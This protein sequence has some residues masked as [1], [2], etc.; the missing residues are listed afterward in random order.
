MICNV[1]EGNEIKM[2]IAFMNLCHC[3]PTIVARVANKLTQNENFDM[4]I[5]VDVKTDIEPFRN[6]LNQNS[7]VYFIENRKKVYWGGYNA[8][9]ATFELLRAALL[10]KKKY[11]YFVLLQNLD[12]PIRSNAY[13]E[14]FFEKNKGT[15]FIRGCKIARSK[16]WH[17][18]RKYKIYNKRD[19][20]FYITNHSVIRKY[21]RYFRLTLQSTTTIG[22]N[23]VIKENNQ[24]YNIYYGAA[25]WGIT[26]ECAKYIVEFEKTHPNFNNRM[27]HIQFPDEEYFHT[28]VHNSEFK[29]RCMKYDEP[30]KR[31]L[32]NWRNLHYFEFPKEV[33]VFNEKDFDKIIKQDVLF[34]RKVKSGISERLMDMIDEFSENE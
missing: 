33:T 10:S 12:Y 19:D 2:K 1:V 14:K 6:L 29:Y 26:R 24:S 16:D 23:G 30:E 25:Q 17:Y 21:M 8:I 11:D 9:E 18:T 28:V 34:I 27:K 15:E 20:D 22:F 4:Y 5:H 13:I 7:Q 31:W 32:V 3:D